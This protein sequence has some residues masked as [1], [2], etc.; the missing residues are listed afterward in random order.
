MPV[1]YDRL[2]QL[3]FY[4]RVSGWPEVL[5]LVLWGVPY[6]TILLRAA[7][8]VLSR[9]RPQGRTGSPHW[10]VRAIDNQYTVSLAMLLYR[11]FI[12]ALTG[13]GYLSIPYVMQLSSNQ[14]VEILLSVCLRMLHSLFEPYNNLLLCFAVKVLVEIPTFYILYTGPLQA[15]YSNALLILCGFGLMDLII[16]AAMARWRWHARKAAAVTAGNLKLKVE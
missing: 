15:P 8:R 11:C 12:T 6:A 2:A 10:I 14:R 16:H 7:Y 1:C 4:C 3:C 9:G 5:S 13:F